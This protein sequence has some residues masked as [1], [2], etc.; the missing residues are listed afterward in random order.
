MIHVEKI[1]KSYDGFP[2]LNQVS[3]T[4]RPGNISLLTGD[5]GAGKSTTLKILSGLTLADSGRAVIAE[6][7]IQ[8]ERRLAQSRLSFLPQGTVFQPAMTPWQLMHFYAGL[9]SIP[10]HRIEPL[11]KQLDLFDIRHKA[12]GKLSGGM[13][14]R[15]ALALF[16]LPDAPVLILDEPGISLDPAWRN[17]LRHILTTQARHGKTVLITTHL[18]AEW[19]SS[20]HERFICENGR[21]LPQPDSDWHFSPR[22]AAAG[23]FSSSAGPE[24]WNQTLHP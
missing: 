11:L 15:L 16:L 7:D 23:G 14:Q 9:R 6:A 19:E 4:A 21:I 5:N 20:A 24:I 8:R 3:F 10:R 13:Q 12:A 2:V 1:T 18:L 17:E 22:N